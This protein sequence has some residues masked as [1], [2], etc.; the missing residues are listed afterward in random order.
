VL[1]THSIWSTILSERFFQKGAIEL[2][3]YEM[4]K[5]LSGVKS[6]DTTVIIPILENSQDMQA[7][8]QDVTKSISEGRISH[9]FLLRGHGLYTWAASLDE[10]RNQI[11]AL[12]FLFEVVGRQQ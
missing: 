9:A 7:L 6:H 5:A 3:G 2:S 12:E 11:E 4:L 10:A 8:A 1:H